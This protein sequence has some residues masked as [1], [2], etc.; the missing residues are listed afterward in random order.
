MTT[1][2]ALLQALAGL[3]CGYGRPLTL[4]EALVKPEGADYA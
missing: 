2:A 4:D 3:A 1:G